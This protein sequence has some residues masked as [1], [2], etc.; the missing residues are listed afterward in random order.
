MDYAELRA[1][2]RREQEL[3]GR[4]IV[5]AQFLCT[6]KQTLLF[7]ARADLD[8]PHVEPVRLSHPDLDRFAAVHFRTPGGVRMLYEDLGDGGVAAWE[9]FAGLVAPLADWSQP[10]DLVYLVPHGILHDLPLHTLPVAGQPLIVRN[11]VAYAPTAAVLRHTLRAGP[12]RGPLR[13]AAVF[14]DSRGDL[15]SARAEA[16]A[17]AELLGVEPLLGPDVRTAP[18]LGALGEAEVVHI[19]GH[20]RVAL[21]DGFDSRL[22]LAD[23]EAL[24]AADVLRLRSRARLVVLSG[25]ETGLSEQRPGDELVG[26]TR[27]LLLSG[28]SGIVS[29]QWRVSDASTR[30]LLSRFHR[31]A[32]DP[33]TTPADALRRAMLEIRALPQYRHFYH[34]GGFILAG[35]WR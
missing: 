33:T 32:R 16:V 17:V 20:G 26:F 7:V 18:V 19:A 10:Q 11:P 21:A 25:C 27:A 14:G 29:G 5:V 15:P 28:V 4:R 13:S 1:L 22:E 2:L 12:D 34:W 3:T 8:A 30:D 23:G 31:A 9:R 35:S 24:R 6:A